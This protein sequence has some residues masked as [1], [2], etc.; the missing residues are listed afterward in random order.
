[1]SSSISVELCKTACEHG[2]H[3]VAVTWLFLLLYA[4]RKGVET[5]AYMAPSLA[6]Q[7]TPNGEFRKNA[8]TTYTS[9]VVDFSSVSNTIVRIQRGR[10]SFMH[11]SYFWPA[12]TESHYLD[13]PAYDK[14]HRLWCCYIFFCSVM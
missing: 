3:S 1:M 11:L 10:L 2:L 7:Y 12:A 8:V 13:G 14:L 4:F 6:L 9:D 5:S